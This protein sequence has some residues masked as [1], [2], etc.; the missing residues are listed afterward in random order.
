VGTKFYFFITEENNDFI[1]ITD[2]DPKLFSDGKK[3]VFRNTNSN[4]AVVAGNIATVTIH[5]STPVNNVVTIAPANFAAPVVLADNPVK[6]VL[7]GS[8]E[9]F[10][11]EKAVPRDTGGNISAER[12]V[13]S[14]T[15]FAEGLYTLQQ[16]DNTNLIVSEK[17]YFLISSVPPFTVNGILL[18]DYNTIFN[19]Q[20]KKE[21]HVVIQL[22]PRNIHWVYNVDI[23]RYEDP[24]EFAAKRI[25][26][27]DLQLDETLSAPS[28]GTT[29]SKTIVSSLPN[30][31][32]WY[33]N[34]K[35]TFR[36]S[37]PVPIH[38]KS[39]RR[40]LLKNT[41]AISPVIINNMPNPEP[42]MIKE[43]APPGSGV[44]EAE[45]FLKV[46]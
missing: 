13:F 15:P 5:N 3:Y 44:Y 19:A 27:A 37:N 29:F 10:I 42:L 22:S 23:E 17:K 28:V 43:K 2:T 1:N 16:V 11:M 20:A 36:S 46:K 32:D 12:L 34:D 26:P 7:R 45:M 25:K 39:Y 35:V 14:D 24:V 33:I 40:L 9:E 30:P 31:A 38:K 41:A 21:I 4:T 18:I 8:E 6:L